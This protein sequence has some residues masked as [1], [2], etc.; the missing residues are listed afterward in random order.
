MTKIIGILGGMGPV[1]T[2]DLYQKIV[3][4]TPATIDQEHLQILIYNNPKI[5]PRTGVL[6][7]SFDNP[8]IELKKSAI[9]LENAGV[10]F[11]I[12]PCHTAHL[13]YDELKNAVT[14]PFYS[15][16]ENTVHTIKKRKDYKNIQILIL[17]TETTINNNLYQKAFNN[18]CK[19][20]IP[21][22]REQKIITNTLNSIKA[23]FI[24]SN[25]YIEAL[26]QILLEYKKR[27]IDLVLGGC[28]ELP[29]IFPYLHNEIEKIDP[30]LLLAMLAINKAK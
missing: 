13:W 30:T 10:D 15:M 26:N 4:N 27:G 19:I 6:T 21:S 8:L 11:I 14:I 23:G 16:V 2:I 18:Y 29:L 5:P 24:S 20:T 3:L 28:T 25:P 7:N 9:L 22:K 12:M 1:A 17:A